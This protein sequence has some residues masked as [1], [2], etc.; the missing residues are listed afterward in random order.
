[1]ADSWA[2]TILSNPATVARAIRG[3]KGGMEIEAALPNPARLRRLPPP[4]A[5]PKIQIP[6][7]PRAAE[8]LVRRE[9][10]SISTLEA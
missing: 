9:I 2:Q 10:F 7:N 5:L 1:M 4:R 6:Q 8:Q 3:E